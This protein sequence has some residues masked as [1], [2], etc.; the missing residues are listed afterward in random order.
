M[1]IEKEIL[2]SIDMD[3]DLIVPWYFIAKYA[4]EQGEDLIDETF[5]ERL[6]HRIYNNI[7][8]LHHRYVPY[9]HSG[10]YPPAVDQALQEV[11]RIYDA[12]NYRR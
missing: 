6:E 10:E 5:V 11:K 2:L 3:F 4:Q 8:Q 7:D 9:V 1:N 12:E